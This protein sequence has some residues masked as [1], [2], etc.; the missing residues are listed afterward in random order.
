MAQ[1]RPA[2]VVLNKSDLPGFLFAGDVQVRVP[3]AKVV[4]ASAVAEGGIAG[5]EAALTEVVTAGLKPAA[6]VMVSHVRHRQ[7][8][9]VAR[10]A[11]A[12]VLETLSGDWPLD[13]AAQDLQSAIRELGEIGGQTA[14]ERVIE[15]IFS[16]FCVGK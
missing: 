5:L 3:G 13:L 11:L 10:D 16:R 12:A 9:E 6:E 8:L 14:S 2:L 1:D 15:E 4:S 7:S